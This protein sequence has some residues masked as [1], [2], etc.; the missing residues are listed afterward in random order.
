MFV[1]ASTPN[2][3][4]PTPHQLCVFTVTGDDSAILGAP[5]QVYRLFA[6]SHYGPEMT[7]AAKWSPDSVSPAA[8][9]RLAA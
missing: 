6:D 8:P 5:I 2:T 4:P 7:I 9:S 3:H 1:V